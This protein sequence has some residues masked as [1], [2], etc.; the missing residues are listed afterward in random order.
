MCEQSQHNL[1]KGDRPREL[2]RGWTGFVNFGHFSKPCPERQKAGT[3]RGLRGSLLRWASWMEG[4]QTMGREGAVRR[5]PKA[6]GASY[7]CEA[8]TSL[9]ECGVYAQTGSL[10]PMLRSSL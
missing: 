8:G 3:A 7:L 2:M 1:I 4:L 9:A 5:D 6:E 10:V